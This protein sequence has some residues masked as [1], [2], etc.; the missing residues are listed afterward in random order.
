MQDVNRLENL[1]FKAHSSVS[2]HINKNNVEKNTRKKE[3]ARRFR[4]H[5]VAEVVRGPSAPSKPDG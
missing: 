4:Q 5:H 1:N 2:L 3:G